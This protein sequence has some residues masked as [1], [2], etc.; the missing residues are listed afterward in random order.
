[1]CG[2]ASL[3]RHGWQVFKIDLDVA[4]LALEVE[5]FAVEP[6]EALVIRDDGHI[7]GSAHAGDVARVHEHAVAE[8][9][10]SGRGLDGE[11]TE[12]DGVLQGHGA[13]LDAVF[14]SA[15]L[16]LH[17]GLTKFDGRFADERDA[18]KTRVEPQDDAR[19]NVRL[20]DPTCAEFLA[21]LAA[22]ARLVGGAGDIDHV[23]FAAP[24]FVVPSQ[25]KLQ[26]VGSGNRFLDLT[27]L[28]LEVEYDA[29]RFFLEV[30]QLQALAGHIRLD[31]GG[32]ALELV[33]VGDAG[34]E[35]LCQV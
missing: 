33:A 24:V 34:I 6:S 10:D 12:V 1:M 23:D 19:D 30:Q 11:L 13:P 2:V 31:A 22:V 4:S 3:V 14:H 27:L 28:V 7:D 25:D 32:H 8:A 18:L 35:V 20:P 29:G 17:G 26:S 5:V 15:Q 21:L 9:L 16:L